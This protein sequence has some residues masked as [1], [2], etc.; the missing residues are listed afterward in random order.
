VAESGAILVDVAVGVEKHVAAGTTRSHFPVI[1]S[2]RLIR[3]GIVDEH[4]TA[5]AEITGAR[6]GDSQCE[7]NSDSCVDRVAAIRQHLRTG[8]GRQGILRGHHSGR[9]EHGM[10]QIV[11]TN[12]GCIGRLR[13]GRGQRQQQSHDE[14]GQLAHG[15]S[16]RQFNKVR[17][18]H[19]ACRVTIA[20]RGG[21]S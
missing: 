21:M 19:S 20:L 2:D 10:M 5:T 17:S 16:V 9:P 7:T 12:N 18:N 11:I 14:T 3:P 8:L 4:K 15:S 1:D 6:Q 13:V